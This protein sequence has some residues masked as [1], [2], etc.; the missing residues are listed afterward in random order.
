MFTLEEVE[1][2]AVASVVGSKIGVVLLESV[3]YACEWCCWTN[4]E[5]DIAFESSELSELAL[6]FEVISLCRFQRSDIINSP[7]AFLEYLKYFLFFI[8][9]S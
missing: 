3:D 2:D 9:E 4:E 7:K 1:T 5:S 6:L 8:N